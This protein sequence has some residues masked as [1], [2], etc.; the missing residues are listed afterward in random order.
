MGLLL[1]LAALLVLA[2]EQS[3]VRF[4]GRE[5]VGGAAGDV[6]DGAA[7]SGARVEGKQV[8]RVP[9]DESRIWL[10]AADGRFQAYRLEE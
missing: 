4:E 2:D 3:S 8:W 6:P 5:Y 7:P 1:L 10:Q 9:G